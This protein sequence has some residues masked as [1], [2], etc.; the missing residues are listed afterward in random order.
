MVREA[1]VSGQFYPGTEH[2]LDCIMERFNSML[3]SA[4]QDDSVLQRSPRA[5]IV[6]HAGYIYS[7][8]TANVAYRMLANTRPKRVI[9][10]G[11][12]HRVYFEG[13]SGSFFDEIKTPYGNLPV[14]KAYLEQLKEK[15]PIQFHQEAHAEHST[16]T[17]FPFIYHYLDGAKTIEFVYGKEDPQELS[18]IIDFL[19]DDPDNAVIISTDLSHFYKLE[20]ANKLDSV[21]IQAIAQSNEEY[22]K[23]GCEACGGIGVEAM[24]RASK[25]KQLKAQVLDYRTSADASGDKSRVVG[26]VSAAYY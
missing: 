13:V 14:D 7:G 6:P 4:L 9:V 3:D 18:K 17:Q 16:E 12:S 26:Y 25:N 23:Q 10:F 20:E 11:P 5:I 21:C 22:L 15:F 19:L 8:F 2:E 24:I 1:V